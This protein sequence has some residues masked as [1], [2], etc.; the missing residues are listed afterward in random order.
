MKPSADHPKAAK[1]PQADVDL[2]TS[3]PSSSPEMPHEHDQHVGSTGGT[4]SA[5]VQQGAKDLKRGL[6]DTSRAPEANRA[7][8]KQKKK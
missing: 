2:S 5:A 8:Q 6:Q 1:N 3:R 4:P 7:Y